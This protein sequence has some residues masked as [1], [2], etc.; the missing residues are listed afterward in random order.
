MIRSTRRA[1]FG[2]ASTLAVVFALASTAFACTVYY[3]KLTVSGNG[4]GN[5][6]KSIDGNGSGAFQWCGSV[7]AFTASDSTKSAFWTTRTNDA[8]PS[9]TVS[10]AAATA[11]GNT[12]LEGGNYYVGIS[13]GFWDESAQG[14]ADGEEDNCHSLIGT[15][16]GPKG[17]IIDSGFAINAT[18]GVGSAT[19]SGTT[20]NG[21]TLS[22]TINL[23]WN[24]IC[25]FKNTGVE[26]APA[27]AL[28]FKS[29]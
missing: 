4:T 13:N 1:L 18:T 2:T 9:L 29:V 28:N 12:K 17:T 15:S 7:P 20:P 24:T 6:S 26:F 5:A 14:F 3:G 10:T 8:S 25:V 11:C 21:T 23:G 19:Y 16:T 22:D 27:N